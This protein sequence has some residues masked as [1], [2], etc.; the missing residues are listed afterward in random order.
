MAVKSTKSR[1]IIGGT[2]LVCALAAAATVAWWSHRYDQTVL[3]YITDAGRTKLQ[4]YDRQIAISQARSDT[5]RSDVQYVVELTAAVVARGKATGDGRDFQNALALLD[6][7]E[8]RI[9]TRTRTEQGVTQL[10]ELYAARARVMMA[11]HHFVEARA[12]A[13]KAL[14]KYPRESG[15]SAIAGEAAVQAG[16]LNGGEAYLRRLVQSEPTIPNNLIGLAYWA[17]IAG[18]LEQASELLKRAPDVSFPKPL[19]RLR[20]A[21]IYAVH[22]DVQSKLGRLPLARQY[23]EAALK[24]EP[25]FAQ[26]RAGVADVARYEGKEAEAEPL[27]RDLV[28]SEWPNA[29]YQVKLAALREALG[30]AAEAKQLRRAAEQYYEWSVD[31]GFDGYLRPLA[32]LKLANGDYRDAAKY[33]ERDLSLRPNSESKAIYRNIFDQ[34]AAAGSALGRNALDQ[35]RT[36]ASTVVATPVQP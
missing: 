28:A 4:Y 32:L 16:D 33:A 17:E 1:R 18:D 15:L 5:N 24:E 19:P 21:Y 23:Y 13:E 36:A 11:N 7:L 2:L 29:D 10:P 14:L 22:G 27:L 6:E 3:P 35:Y 12:I 31:S 30:D 34:A 25:T 26:A 20:L 9:A 8:A